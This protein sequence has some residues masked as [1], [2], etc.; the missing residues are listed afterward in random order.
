MEALCQERRGTQFRVRVGVAD[1]ASPN[2]A[3]AGQ[4]ADVLI[5]AMARGLDIQLPSA[6]AAEEE[7]TQAEQLG[8][9][10]RDIAALY[11]VLKKRAEQ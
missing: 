9:G 2:C 8:Y 11:E 7:L 3:V 1:A 5:L 10:A 6:K 4:T